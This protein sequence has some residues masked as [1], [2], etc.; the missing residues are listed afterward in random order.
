[1]VVLLYNTLHR[2]KEYFTPL[3]E[4]VGFYACGPT[5][6]NY[7]HIGNLRSYIFMD[8]LHRT[9]LFTRFKVHLV[10][11]ITDV[12]HL[13]DDADQGEDKIELEAEKENRS[14]WEIADYY[15]KAFLKDIKELNIIM[16]RTIC[17]AT[18]H[19]K[20][21]IELIKKIEANGFTYRTEDG[22]YF[23]TGKLPDYG[24]L[25]P[26]FSPEKLQAGKR[27]SIKG[28]KNITDFALWKFSPEDKKRAMEWD[29]PWGVGFP[30]WHI[31]CTAMA[32]HYLGEEF[33]IHTGG[34]DHI[35][36]HHTN[37]I[38]QAQGAF[39]HDHVKYWL[40]NEFLVLKDS[41]MSKSKGGFITLK[42]L[43][44][45]NY[46]PLDYR[47][48]N[49]LTHYR[50]Q[51]TFS[52]DALSAARTARIKMQEKVSELP[53]EAGRLSEEA[54]EYSSLFSGH[55]TDDLNMPEA[56]AT[57]HEMLRSDISDEEKSA[58]ITKWDEV[59]GLGLA[60][61][62]KL[63]VPREIEELL[64]ERQRLRDNKE[65]GK[66]DIIREEIKNKGWEVIDDKGSSRVKK[67]P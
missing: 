53:K 63:S 22:I 45:K 37:E 50:K 40:H 1:M 17:R 33:D 32:C 13:T 7:A 6:Y 67:I 10:M 59:L 8:L 29:S 30:G 64:A 36:V 25:I 42:D 28:K 65:F 18:E 16:P 57:V 19:I 15:T 5:V 61:N 38:A 26:N 60:V 2:K 23:D 3:K 43:K 12:G 52:W 9:L 58:L 62:K 66:A 47:Y 39:G 20:E 41:K 51:L 31:E 44:E 54:L 11:N 55:I 56:I 48:L 4:E 14:V 46:H 34:I 21:Q 35:P 24:K 27:V 49:L